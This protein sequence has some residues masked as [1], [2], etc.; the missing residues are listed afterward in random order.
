LEGQ[1]SSLTLSQ[2]LQIL[3]E[4]EHGPKGLMASARSWDESIGQG[5]TSDI[6]KSYCGSKTVKKLHMRLQKSNW[7]ASFLHGYH[8][9]LEYCTKLE[10]HT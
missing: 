1:R 7:R 4:Q 2:A 6:F 8:R 9:I 3:S 10:L 5:G